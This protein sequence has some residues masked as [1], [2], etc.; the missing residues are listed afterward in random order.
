MTLG[1]MRDVQTNMFI[2]I[3]TNPDSEL[4]LRRCLFF[5]S[6]PHASFGKVRPVV[7]VAKDIRHS[8]K[9]CDYI[10][11]KSEGDHLNASLEISLNYLEKAT[12]TIATLIQTS[13]RREVYTCGNHLE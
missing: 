10:Q 3:A 12:M 1:I 6:S 11:A 7:L 9:L 4:P 13:V 5:A 8:D 2:E